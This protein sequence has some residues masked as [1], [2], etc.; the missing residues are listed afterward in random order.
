M[1]FAILDALDALKEQ[2]KARL[3]EEL[4][5]RLAHSHFV[6]WR[7]MLHLATFFNH[8]RID[9]RIPL[10]VRLVLGNEDAFQAYTDALQERFGSSFQ[11]YLG[12]P[13]GYPE[14]RYDRVCIEFQAAAA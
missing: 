5:K 6:W 14:A 2:E 1:D 9:C 4:P 10:W 13:I 12:R 8:D 7:R 11:V 3:R